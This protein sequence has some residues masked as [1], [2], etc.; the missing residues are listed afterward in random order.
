[1]R[2][3]IV[4]AKPQS[5]STQ[6]R[7]ISVH[8]KSDNGF[9][10]WGN[11]LFAATIIFVWCSLLLVFR[12]NPRLDLNALSFFYDSAYCQNATKKASCI[13]FPLSDNTALNLLRDILHI[14]PNLIGAILIVFLVIQYRNGKSWKN[15][16]FR[17]PAI[18]LASLLIGPLL[19]VNIIFKEAFGRV[20][21]RSIEEFG[22]T[23]DFTLPGDI[24]GQC[25]SNCSFV[26][27][28]ASIGGWFL[29]C[30]LLFPPQYRSSAY[31]GLFILGSFMALLRLAFGAHFLSDVIL[32]YL[33]PIIVCAILA[34]I[35]VYYE[36]QASATNS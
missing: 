32:G 35:A 36:K 10:F 13:G 3:P 34:T 22:G 16:R 28:E 24:A 21:P 33:V 20:R 27:G 14:A 15:E 30:G 31:A 1:M 5:S 17:N 23:M 29:V 6:A 18:V 12:S 11:P 2:L 26:S 4:H 8:T 19:T 7:G 9:G 25:L